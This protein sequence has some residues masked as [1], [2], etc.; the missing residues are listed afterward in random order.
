[1]VRMATRS[2]EPAM[3][4]MDQLRSANAERSQLADA[5]KAAG[6]R[7]RQAGGSASASRLIASG[8]M[9]CAKSAS[10]P[11]AMMARLRV[12]TSIAVAVDIE[13]PK[14]FDYSVTVSDFGE[15]MPARP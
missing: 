10:V 12:H 1:M 3:S 2:A 11:S 13:P 5:R 6:P 14:Y 4:S 9:T 7:V 8:W 15:Y